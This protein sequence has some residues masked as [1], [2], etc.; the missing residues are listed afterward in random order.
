LAY[1]FVVFCYDVFVYFWLYLTIFTGSC[2]VTG[3]Q[4]N[5]SKR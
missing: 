1:C 5:C 4:L 3:L 2:D